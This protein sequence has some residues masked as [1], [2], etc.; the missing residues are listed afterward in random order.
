MRET[1]SNLFYCMGNIIQFTKKKVWKCI[2]QKK[3]KSRVPCFSVTLYPLLQHL[4]FLRILTFCTE[5]WSFTWPWTFLSSLFSVSTLLG[6]IFCRLKPA[7]VLLSF[8]VVERIAT[9]FLFYHMKF[10]NLFI[11]SLYGLVWQEFALVSN[12]WRIKF[13]VMRLLAVLPSP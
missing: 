13:S 4:F 8:Y 9:I 11:I 3:E 6:L 2:L 5:F 7:V 1:F 12:P 10:F